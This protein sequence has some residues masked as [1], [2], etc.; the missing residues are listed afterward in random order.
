MPRKF[1]EPPLFFFLLFPGHFFLEFGG[2]W[3][4]DTKI[5]GWFYVHPGE[6]PKGGG[7]FAQTDKEL[8]RVIPEGSKEAEYPKDHRLS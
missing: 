5:G 4:G 1:L 6:A 2:L 8:V 7:K 3:E